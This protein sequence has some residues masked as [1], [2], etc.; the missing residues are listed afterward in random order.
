M[1]PDLKTRLFHKWFLLTRA[2]TLGVRGLAFDGEGRV[3]LVKHTYVAG[4]HLPGGGVEPGQTTLD[5]LA[6]ELR[7]E[8]N[9]EIGDAPRLRSVHFSNKVTQRDHVVVY[10]CENVRQTAPKT[11][12]REIL[13]AAFFALDALPDGVTQS[14]LARI[15]EFSQGIEADPYW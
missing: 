2:M 6:M 14:S 13:A 3:L 5:A 12:D 1:K 8:A 11:A 7:E 10:L 15:R 9:T 4:W